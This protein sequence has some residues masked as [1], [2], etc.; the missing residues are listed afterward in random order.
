LKIYG[1]AY[2][3]AGFAFLLFDGIWLS[4]AANRFYRPLMGEM[5]IEGFR[6]VPAI[7]FYLIYVA[8]IVVFA[9][10][11]ALAADRWSAAALYGALLGLF[12]YATYDLTNQATLRG[13]PIM[14]TIVDMCWGTAVTA[15]AATVGFLVS[16]SLMPPVQ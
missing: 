11:P 12:A 4:F 13:W 2:L 1:T 10:A 5:L 3:A 8:G 14:V 16:R 7:C 6:L 15:A 9:V